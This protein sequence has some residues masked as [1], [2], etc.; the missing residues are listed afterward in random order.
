MII[1]NSKE[2]L[3]CQIHSMV[4][5]IEQLI[6]HERLLIVISLYVRLRERKQSNIFQHEFN[7][8]ILNLSPILHYKSDT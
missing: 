7:F 6:C 8:C 5:S 4:V 2:E 3:E 1:M